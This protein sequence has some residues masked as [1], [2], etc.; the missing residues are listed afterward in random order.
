MP[1]GF[2]I[3]I[4]W[5]LN[6]FRW[7]QKNLMLSFICIKKT[8][9]ALSKQKC[10]RA[11]QVAQYCHQFKHIRSQVCSQN[12]GESHRENRGILLNTSAV[13]WCRVFTF[14][15]VENQKNFRL[16]K[17][18]S[19]QISW[20][21][22][23][24]S[25]STLQMYEFVNNTSCLEAIYVIRHP[26]IHPFTFFH[27]LSCTQGHGFNLPDK[28]ANLSLQQVLYKLLLCW[29]VK[30]KWMEVNISPHHDK[31]KNVRVCWCLACTVY[32]VQLTR[33]FIY[34]NFFIHSS[35]FQFY[36]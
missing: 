23:C 13:L 27:C 9:W 14:V 19:R 24:S 22:F 8:V 5:W 18:R 3:F 7:C 2:W 29:P 26:S 10:G 34:H 21:L 28:T 16:P 17:L 6:L 31:D 33:P 25:R 30:W 12:L 4:W 11:N 15:I 20:S 32:P 36:W 35:T 1:I